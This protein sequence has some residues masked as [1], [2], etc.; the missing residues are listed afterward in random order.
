MGTFLLLL[1]LSFILYL[2][3]SRKNK[4]K[5]A[6]VGLNHTNISDSQASSN[7]SPDR[8][9]KKDILSDEEKRREAI[10]SLI[11][12]IKITVSTGNDT[13]LIDVTS[14]EYKLPSSGNAT[15]SVPYW[16]HQYVYGYNEINSATPEQKAFYQR[17]KINFLNGIY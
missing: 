1:F 11:D 9:L 17:F 14:Q 6:P 10:K 13:S 4:A 12:S 5:P 16:P 8:A 7:L 15:G 2:I 3:L